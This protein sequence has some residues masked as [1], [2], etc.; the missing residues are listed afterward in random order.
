VRRAGLL[1]KAAGAQLVLVHVVDDDQPIELVDLESRE[2][3]RILAEQSAS[4]GELRDAECRPMVVTGDPFDGILRAAAATEA[5]LIVLGAHRK[6]VLRDIFVGTT[7]ERVIRTGSCPVLM[8]NAEAERS[9]ADVLA[10]VDMSP[11]SARAIRTAAELRLLE[12]ARLT[13]VHAFLAMAAGLMARSAIT[14]EDIQRYVADEQVR[15]AGELLAFLEKEAPGLQNWALRV[16]EGTPTEVIG[17]AVAEIRPDL[18]L[19]GTQ[20]R[21]GLPRV[22]LGSVAEEVLKSVD[23]DVLAV[24]PAR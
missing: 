3:E 11:H 2:A 9:Y 10:A 6:Q 15:A 7:V 14:R 5:D 22:L 12:G 1:A 8:V 17:A 13:L 19:I 21:S 16:R 20:G 24:P 23:V 18:L 4:I